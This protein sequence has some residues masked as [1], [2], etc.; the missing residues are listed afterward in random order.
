MLPLLLV[1]VVALGARPPA[2]TQSSDQ[3]RAWYLQL[4][5]RDPEVREQARINLMGIKRRDLPALEKVVA[6]SRPVRASQAAVL[7]DIVTHVH[8]AGEPYKVAPNTGGFLG[9]RGLQTW[10]SPPGIVVDVRIQGFCAYRMLREGDVIVGIEEM[11]GIQFSTSNELTGVL[12]GV[13][14][15]TT[16]TFR[17]LRGGT[18]QR[19]P[20]QL[21][22]R[23]DAAVLG[24]PNDA[25]A[26]LESDRQNKAEEYW[27]RAFAPLIEDE[28]VSAL[29]P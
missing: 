26:M 5:D 1:T 7:Y 27:S 20:I 6:D 22:A 25:M 8:M 15:G 12:S 9:L 14:P 19:V 17:V 2:T 3:I 4:A 10:D 11:P 28:S 18:I 16:L 13:D 21:D 24:R 23:P 29:Q